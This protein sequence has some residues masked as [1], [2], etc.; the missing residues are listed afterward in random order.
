MT[1]GRAMAWACNVVNGK[2]ISTDKHDV[3]TASI[4]DDKLIIVAAEG[5]HDRLSDCDG[6]GKPFV[7]VPEVW[8]KP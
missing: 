4:A 2:I 1:N 3:E 5:V 8:S 6:P 7:L